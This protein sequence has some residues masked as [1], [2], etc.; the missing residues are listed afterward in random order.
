MTGRRPRILFALLPLLMSLLPAVAWETPVPRPH[1]VKAFKVSVTPAK[2]EVVLSWA[3]GTP[4]FVI[5]RSDT[6]HLDAGGTVEY[7]SR[8]HSDRRFVDHD[9]LQF[10]QRFWYAV[11]DSNSPPQVFAM[12]PSVLHEGDEATIRGV[13]FS[14]D[15]TKNLVVFEGGQEVHP[16]G[17]CDVTGFRIVIPR[18]AVSGSMMFV[19]P[20]GVATLGNEPTWTTWK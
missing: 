4:P 11:Y 10:G 19:S 2:G 15:C 14:T 18:P 7:L 12:T 17:D 16:V 5:V 3:S 9:A 20:T 1:P 13:G 8:R 6:E